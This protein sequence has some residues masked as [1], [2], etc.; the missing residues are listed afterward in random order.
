MLSIRKWNIWIYLGNLKVIIKCNLKRVINFRIINEFIGHHSRNQGIIRIGI[1][2]GKTDSRKEWKYI[3]IDKLND[4]LV[5]RDL[6]FL[7]LD[8]LK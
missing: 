3:E 2:N 6:S 8:V 1:V 4:D 7:I 5:L